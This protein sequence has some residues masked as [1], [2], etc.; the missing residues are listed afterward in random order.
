MIEISLKRLSEELQQTKDQNSD[1][2]FQLENVRL[3]NSALTL[4]IIKSN[5]DSESA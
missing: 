3:K 1:L 5:A 4:E 2:R